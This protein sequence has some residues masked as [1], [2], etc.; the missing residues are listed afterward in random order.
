MT[1]GA[2]EDAPLV[3]R[4]RTGGYRTLSPNGDANSAEMGWGAKPDCD[5]N[6]TTDDGISPQTMIST[7]EATSTARVSGP[8]ASGST[9]PSGL[10]FMNIARMTGR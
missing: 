5:A 7:A 2:P 9:A 4:S 8:V 6:P 1:R 10:G 3:R